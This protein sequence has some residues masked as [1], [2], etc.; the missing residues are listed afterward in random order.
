MG[1]SNVEEWRLLHETSGGSGA[2]NMAVDEALLREG[3]ASGGVPTI[4]LYAWN[5]ACVS[6]G[7]FQPHSDVDH[8]EVARRGYGIVRRPTG[9][10]GILHGDEVTYSLVGSL[11]HPKLAGGIVEAYRK[12][13]AGLLFGLRGLG[14][15]ATALSEPKRV[16]EARRRAAACFAAPSRFEI[17][18]GRRKLVGSAQTRSGGWLLQ[19]GSVLRA[20]DVAAWEAVFPQGERRSGLSRYMVSI[21]EVLQSSPSRVEVEAAL[22]AGFEE[23]LHIQLVPGTMTDRERNRAQKLVLDRYES[24]EWLESR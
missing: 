1:V 2:W 20:I 16:S 15:P 3:A 18:V 21:A 14:V 19:H 13:S 6:L 9:G 10:R 17:T 24:A 11:N 23:A 8:Q 12:I 22:I 4:R 5:P 7:A